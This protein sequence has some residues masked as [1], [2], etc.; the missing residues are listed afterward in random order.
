MMKGEAHRCSVKN[1]LRKSF[2]SSVLWNGITTGEDCIKNE[3]EVQDSSCAFTHPKCKSQKGSRTSQKSKPTPDKT[4]PK[5]YDVSLGG[6]R[7]DDAT[8]QRLE[9]LEARVKK[10]EEAQELFMQGLE[11]AA[12]AMMS[13]NG[14][15]GGMLRTMIPLEFR[16]S[17]DQFIK[18]RKEARD[19]KAKAAAS[20]TTAG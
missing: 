1:F 2:C 17:L 15:M 18:I 20:D 13:A 3:F 16:S 5:V 7:M 12:E 6:V 8:Q 11:K 19:A 4:S 14:P 10:L 9:Q